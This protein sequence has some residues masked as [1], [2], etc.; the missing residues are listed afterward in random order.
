MMT[1]ETYRIIPLNSTFD[2]NSFDCDSEPL[3]HY[4]RHFVTQDIKRKLTN[5]FI[6][7][8]T[9]HQIIGYYTLSAHSICLSDLPQQMKKKLPRYPTIPSIK[10]GRLAVNQPFRG[11][12]FG[13]VLLIDALKRAAN[14]EIGAYAL[15]VDAKD[16]NAVRFYQHY[17]FISLLDKTDTLFYP[18]I[19]FKTV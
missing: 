17:G 5:C 19:N 18:L 6:L 1:T 7:T 15:L 16:D 8:N 2:R 14:S 12:G 11:Q 4:F 3:T 10:M 13:G 9:T